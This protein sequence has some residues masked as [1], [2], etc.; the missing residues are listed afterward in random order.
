MPRCYVCEREFSLSEGTIRDGDFYC[1]E[2]ERALIELV[3]DV[4]ADI[5]LRN[6]QVDESIK[7][8]RDRILEL[9]QTEEGIIRLVTRRMMKSKI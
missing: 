5:V 2:H 4:E 9:K 7:K 1:D 3:M 8:Y 6:I